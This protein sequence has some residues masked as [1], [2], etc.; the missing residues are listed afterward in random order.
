MPPS[1][2]ATH[3]SLRGAFEAFLQVLLEFDPHLAETSWNGVVGAAQANDLRPRPRP[4]S[5]PWRGDT[6]TTAHD[7]LAVAAADSP[8]RAVIFVSRFSGTR[9]NETSGRSAGQALA[10]IGSIFEADARRKGR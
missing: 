1:K 5:R 10:N 9:S 8:R 6:G 4:R 3:V 2:S 7:R